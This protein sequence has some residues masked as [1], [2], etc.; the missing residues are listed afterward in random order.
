MSLKKDAGKKI[1]FLEFYT[2]LKTVWE[3]AVLSN[4]RSLTSDLT[5]RQVELPTWCSKRLDDDLVNA[6]VTRNWSAKF[7]LRDE[8]LADGYVRR[9]AALG[10]DELVKALAER[11]PCQTKKYWV[12][13]TQPS[14]V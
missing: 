6:H 1:N 5:R 12:S 7:R 13:K 9:S 8:S 3:K 2:W 4:F 14:E 11:N 10:N